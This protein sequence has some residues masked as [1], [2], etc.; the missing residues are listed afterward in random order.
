M[1]TTKI[2]QQG[3]DQLVSAC[4]SIGAEHIARLIEVA[5]PGQT[6]IIFVPWADP[7]VEIE[8][9]DEETLTGNRGLI[10]LVDDN[11]DGISRGSGG[12]HTGLADVVWGCTHWAVISGKPPVLLYEQ[13]A[14]M[15]KAGNRIVLI[16]CT[17]DQSAEERWV[18]WCIANSKKH[19]VA[20]LASPNVAAWKLRD[21]GT[22]RETRH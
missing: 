9:P 20:M 5:I 22:G 11:N 10:T 7:P 4:R 14:Y 1:R 13:A 3:F 12:F 2:D 6:S 8:A 21:E 18:R 16:E 19:S 15:A 17:A